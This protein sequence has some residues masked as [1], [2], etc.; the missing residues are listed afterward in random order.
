MMHLQFNTWD[1]KVRLILS[2]DGSYDESTDKG[3]YEDRNLDLG[4]V[5]RLVIALGDLIFMEDPE[6]KHAGISGGVNHLI[7]SNLSLTVEH[8][9]FTF[10]GDFGAYTALAKDAVSMYDK[11]CLWLERAAGI[12]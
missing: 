6:L 1:M 2:P 11:L 7:C 8:D 3:R 9:S 10:H 4:A 5:N 12:L